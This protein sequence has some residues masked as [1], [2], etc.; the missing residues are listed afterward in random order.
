MARF[1][2]MIRLNLTPEFKS[3]FSERCLWANT[4]ELVKQNSFSWLY[5]EVTQSWFDT[6]GET[7]GNLC[8]LL[9]NKN[10]F[11]YKYV[12]NDLEVTTYCSNYVLTL[13]EIRNTKTQKIKNSILYL[14]CI[15]IVAQLFFISGSTLL[16]SWESWAQLSYTHERVELLCHCFWNEP[17]S[18]GP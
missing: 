4:F 17:F 13:F 2:I 16:C 6:Y 12:R 11:K 7:I 8:V 1:R 14:V 5:H 15:S 18:P 3:L 10:I 9:T